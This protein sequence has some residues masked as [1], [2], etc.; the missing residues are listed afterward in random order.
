MAQGQ[1]VGR[2]ARAVFVVPDGDTLAEQ[3]IL[4]VEERAERVVVN[5]PVAVDGGLVAGQGVCG[6]VGLEFGLTAGGS[7]N[8]AAL[9]GV[10]LQAGNGESSLGNHGAES[11]HGGRDSLGKLVNIDTDKHLVLMTDLG[12]VHVAGRE[13]FPAGAS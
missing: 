9:P 10:E 6:Y 3:G 11:Q 13:G 7:T 8:I 12:E 4:G 5:A 2:V 1:E